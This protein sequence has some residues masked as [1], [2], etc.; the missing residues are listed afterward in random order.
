M[1]LAS[2]RV[3]GLQS[4]VAMLL[5]VVIVSLALAGCGRQRSVGPSSSTVELPDQEVLDFVLT[6]TDEGAIQWKLYARYAAMYD[7]RNVITARGVRVDFFDEKGQR[8]SELKAREGEIN[9]LTRDMTATGNVVLQTTEGTRMSTEQ[10]RF[11]NRTQRI[12]SDKLV[13]VERGGDVLSGTGFES[14]PELK[15]YEFKTKVN[16]TV[17]TGSGAILTNPQKPK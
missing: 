16:A 17:R 12:V 14:D 7:A 6:E 8:S 4:L 13:R 10:M 1:S 9:Q 3:R 11:L 2:D 15:H 5:G